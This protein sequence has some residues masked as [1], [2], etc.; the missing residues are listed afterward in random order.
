MRFAPLRTALLAA[1]HGLCRS[2][3]RTRA[4]PWRRRP[5]RR[6]HAQHNELNEPDAELIGPPFRPADALRA[7]TEGG[8]G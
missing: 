4:A 3:R 2:H 1:P 8:C 6:L 7:A 5:A